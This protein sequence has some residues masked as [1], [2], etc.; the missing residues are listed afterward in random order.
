MT[1]RR[2]VRVRKVLPERRTVAVQLPR[3]LADRLDQAL[4]DAREAQP[5]QVIS[6][7]AMIRHALAE[8]FALVDAEPAEADNG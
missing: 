3:P 6:R 7:A 2:R 4:A 1:T 8:Y 5:G